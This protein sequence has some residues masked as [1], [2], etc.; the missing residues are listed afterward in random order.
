MTT[1]KT[2]STAENPHPYNP[3]YSRADPLVRPM[4]RN[5]TVASHHYLASWAG[6]EI[7]RQGGNAV[8]AAVA[9]SAALGVV[10][11]AMNGPAGTGT[12]LI[13]WADD[14]RTYGLDFSGSVPMA[15]G[16]ATSGDVYFGPRAQL[17]PGNLG[18]WLAA[19]ERF[20]T[21]DR[22]TVFAPAI[23]LAEDG[24]PVSPTLSYYIGRMFSQLQGGESGVAS[25]FAP[26]GRPM[27]PGEILRQPDLGRTYRAIVDGGADVFYTGAIAEQIAR[28][29]SARGGWLSAD[30]LRGFAP[31][32]EEPLAIE[33]AGWRVMTPPPPCSGVQILETLRLLEAFDM[34]QWDATS[35]EYLHLLVEAIKLAR[36]DRVFKGS[37]LQGTDGARWCLSDEHIAALRSSMDLTHAAESEGDWFVSPH[38]THF[39]VADR[40]GNVVSSTQSL[41][42]IFGSGVV[43]DGTGLILNGL[44]FLFDLDPSAPN[45]IEPGKKMDDPMSP[46]IAT[47]PDGNVLAVGSPGGQGILQTNVQMFNDVVHFGMSP[48]AAVESPRVTSWG[49]RAFIDK[50]GHLYDPRSLAI[51]DRLPQRTKDELVRRNHVLEP[52]GE[53]SHAVGAGAIVLRH[54][55]GVLEGGAD[56]RRDGLAYA[57]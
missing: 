45:G 54:A 5:G 34:S 13:H 39:S 41:G 27:Q 50:F 23:G 14:G 33:H 37:S 4:G 31:V 11:P 53:W 25:V 15:A 46:I 17:V 22:T 2:L 7:L 42:A 48:Q 10:E 44:L 16:T 51:E 56:P 32:W 20:G 52:L 29:V 55:N 47:H 28:C 18:G 3:T 19:L 8:D 30:D 21:M 43:V 40:A 35:P 38:T 26:G 1:A 57:F 24:Q 9:V 6:V 49:R 36:Y 12:M